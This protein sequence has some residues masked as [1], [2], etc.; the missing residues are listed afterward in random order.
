MS[1]PTNR[2]VFETGVGWSIPAT[3]VTAG[4]LSGGWQV[5]TAP[6]Q[7]TPIFLF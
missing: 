3:D 2:Q 6:A 7:S 1:M 4:A 5:I